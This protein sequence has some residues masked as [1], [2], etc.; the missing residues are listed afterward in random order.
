MPPQK[1]IATLL[2]ELDDCARAGIKDELASLDPLLRHVSGADE[3]HRDTRGSGGVHAR[4]GAD[5]GGRVYIDVKYILFARETRG[6][7]CTECGRQG[8]FWCVKNSEGF[9]L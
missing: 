1:L 6:N 5:R 9:E 2:K 4:A 3:Q 8:V 7:C